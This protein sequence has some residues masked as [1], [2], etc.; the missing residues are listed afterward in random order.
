MTG[1]DHIIN[2]LSL[3][4]VLDMTDPGNTLEITG[5]SSDTL[6]VDTVGW[7]QTSA[8]DNGTNTTYEYSHDGSSDSI[9][10]TVDDEIIT[11]GI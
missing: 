1:G 2:N 8:V 9:S 3:S 6:S 7:T 4:D 5:D 10:L 11:T